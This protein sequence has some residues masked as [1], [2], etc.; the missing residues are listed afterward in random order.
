VDTAAV[1]LTE[2]LEKAIRDVPAEQILFGSDEPEIDC[3]LELFKLQVLNL[4]EEK[5]RLIFGGNIER[6]LGGRI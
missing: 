3:R 4:P 5:A 2:Y 1:V 6:L